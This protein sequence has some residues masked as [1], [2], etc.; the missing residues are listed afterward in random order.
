MSKKNNRDDFSPGTVK[1]VSERVGLRCSI[2]FCLTKAASMEG[3]GEITNLGVAA[4]ICAAAP[5]GKRYDP[6]MT[7]A[8]RSSP[9]NCIWLCQTHA[10]QIDDDAVTYTPQVLLQIK[11]DAEKKVLK[12][13]RQGR[14][15]FQAVKA[16][17]FVLA[18]VRN[19]FEKLVYDG[20]FIQ[21][22]QIL[23]LLKQMSISDEISD[24]CDY[25]EIVYAY[26]CERD[27]LKH[28]IKEYFSSNTAMHQDEI[29]ALF[30]QFREKEILSAVYHH[31]KSEEI[32]NLAEQIVNDTLIGESVI[33]CNGAEEIDGEVEATDL[34]GTLRHKLVTNVA[35]DEGLL[36]LRTAEGKYIKLYDGE[37]YYSIK[38]KLAELKR[39]VNKLLGVKKK[40]LCDYEEFSDIVKQKEKIKILDKDIQ[41]QIWGSLLTLASYTEDHKSYKTLLSECEYNLH[42][43]SVMKEAELL[44]DIILDI[45]A[46][47][48]E[49]VRRFCEANNSFMLL[50]IYLD[51]LINGACINE[52]GKI[53]DNHKYLF[54]MDV[55]F[56]EQYIKYKRLKKSAKFSPV[57]FLCEYDNFYC[58]D[59]E[60]H[61]YK[62]FYA[63]K[64]KNYRK[65]FKRELTWLNK[66]DIKT[67]KITEDGFLKL[68][69]VYQD[70]N[71][72]VRILELSKHVVPFRIKLEAAEHLR[73]NKEYIP[74]AIAM[75]CE[76]LDCVPDIRGVNR[77][78]SE[79]Y[80]EIGEY[81]KAKI[82]LLSEL[83]LGVEKSDL[84]NL[85]M[86][87]LLTEEIV[88]DK[89][90]EKAKTFV[91]A[92]IYYLIGETYYHSKNN[93]DKAKEFIL[94]SLLLDDKNLESLN[95][96]MIIQMTEEHDPAPSE[97][98]CGVTAKIRN[99]NG[100]ELNVAICEDN[101][102]NMNVKPNNLANIYYYKESSREVESLIYGKVGDEVEFKTQKYEIY[103]LHWTYELVC[104]YAMSVLISQ[105]QVKAFHGKT[106][107][108]SFKE[109]Y[110]F[111][112]K[113]K[114]SAAEAIKIYNKNDGLL[115]VDV[116]ARMLGKKRM[117]T[118]GFLFF[119]NT[120]KIKNILP[121]ADV[122]GEE[123]F[124]LSF[125]TLYLLSLLEIDLT[126][127]K[128][129]DCVVPLMTRRVLLDEIE[130]SI[131]DCK[132]GSVGRLYLKDKQLYRDQDDEESRKRRLR[133]FNRFKRLING[134]DAADKEYSYEYDDELKDFFARKD[135]LAESDLFG[136]IK[137]N[138]GVVLVNDELFNR[139]VAQLHNIPAI[140]FNRFLCLINLDVI[141][142]INC[143][144]KLESLNFG[145]Y[146]TADVY[147][148]IKS[149]IMQL[150]DDE[151]KDAMKR[152]F[153]F[154]TGEYVKSDGERWNYNCEI[155]KDLLITM[156]VDVE[157]CDEIDHLLVRANTYI[158]SVRFPDEFKK[159]LDKI[160]HGLRVE[161]YEKDG[162][163]YCDI[164]LEDNEDE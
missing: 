2:C 71:N 78:L 18:D 133:F 103:S 75:Y 91:D 106:P 67:C 64:N 65:L 152:L 8:E 4:H 90:F 99:K 50:H 63:S 62:A 58:N 84:S 44:H 124:V 120:L 70:N 96:F 1:L 26:Y 3:P 130:D 51:K 41:I 139:H 129:L 164:Y 146:F 89:W 60:F 107:E 48:F 98:S 123:R 56:L 150:S 80:Y 151:K 126:T 45:K 149:K 121:V 49:V 100:E 53:F 109:I 25:F 39:N 69:R 135:M 108:E 154:L 145:N 13:L 81:Y 55:Q 142:H 83:A 7:A 28:L 160:R 127:V 16:T 74:N 10:K 73:Q 33:I 118:Y 138:S 27:I 85:L 116:F 88:F 153:S 112:E 156:K 77:F 47:D 93:S 34:N 31:A 117:E 125:Q 14:G 68:L 5:G 119:E 9:D 140:G 95:A 72:Y 6:N 144:E 59:T 163:M 104:A 30:V 52:V 137:N 136:Y 132:S 147:K 92:K 82:S 20:N 46:V 94:K 15:L 37:F 115:P 131:A 38:V 141:E 23:D 66:A 76:V 105:K 54:E 22:K 12:E 157:N 111:L 158:F 32:K 87:R 43:S 57:K 21:L 113:Q 161:N 61:I 36:N 11:Q 162:K 134:F 155:I 17:G 114:A 97:L 79:C 122:C 42:D 128:S 110:D 35:I 19:C 143:I 101:F 86:L 102:L 148:H 29:I 40:R 24:L 159:I